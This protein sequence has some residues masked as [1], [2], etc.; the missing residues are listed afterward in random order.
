MVPAFSWNFGGAAGPALYLSAWVLASVPG[1]VPGS[2]PV[3]PCWAGSTC[4]L[5]SML[6]GGSAFQTLGKRA[7]SCD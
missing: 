7:T 1:T 4:R 6:Q 2:F 3:G 5:S